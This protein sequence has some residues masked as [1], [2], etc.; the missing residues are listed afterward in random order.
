MSVVS[1]NSSPFQFMTFL[2]HLAVNPCSVT[3]ALPCNKRGA[4]VLLK[5][6]VFCSFWCHLEAETEGP[7]SFFLKAILHHRSGLQLV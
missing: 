3:H 6:D 5:F 4:G 7:I 1:C 2:L